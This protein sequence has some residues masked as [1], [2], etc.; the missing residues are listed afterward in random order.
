MKTLLIL[1]A[2]LFT[3][4]SNVFPQ[5]VGI[6]STGV[7]P[8]GS[9]MLD[10]VST[11]SGLLIPR[12]SMTQRDAISSPVEGLII[13]QTDNAPG[14]YYYDGLSWQRLIT[15]LTNFTESSYG[16][17]STIN[18]GVKLAPNSSQT[19]VDFVIAP[20]GVGGILAREPDGT[21]AGGNKR[22][23]CS[24]DFQTYRDSANQVAGG[25]QSFIGNGYGNRTGNQFSFIGNGLKNTADGMCTM[26]INGQNNT[27][28]K[29]AATIVNGL[30]NS[31]VGIYSIILNGMGDTISNNY[32][33][34]G[35]GRH[36]AINGI[37]SAIL[38]GYFNYTT[39]DYSTIINGQSDT[40]T[41]NY[42]FVHGVNNK[43]QSY[44][45]IVFGFNATDCTG[46]AYGIVATDRLFALGNGTSPTARSNALTILKNANTTVGGS[47]TINGNGSGTSY[48]FPESRGS[49][50]FVLTSDGSGGTTWAA[51]SLTNFIT[52]SSYGNGSTINY[53]VKLTPNS[54]QANVDLVISPK[55]TGALL[56][57]QPDGTTT[58]GNNRGNRSVDFQTYRTDATQVANGAYSF[59]GSGA[60]NTANADYSFVGGGS[61]N[62]ANAGY[63][64]VSGGSGNTANA[65]YSFVGGGSGN[66]ANAGYSLVAGGE[67]NTANSAYTSAV[68]GYHNTAIG[69]YSSIVGGLNNTAIGESSIVIGG[70]NN[71]CSGISSVIVG[72]MNNNCSG[73]FSFVGGGSNNYLNNDYSFIGSG[74]H[75][76]TYMQYSFIG[77]GYNN[78]ASGTQSFIGNGNNSI[79]SGDYSF[80][81]CGNNNTVSGNNAFIGGGELNIS[82]HICCFV[83][84][85]KMNSAGGIYC[86]VG[87][88]YNNSSG[89][90]YS[91]IAGGNGNEAFGKYSSINGG[92]YNT[93]GGDYS[94]VCGGSNNNANA[95]YS[96]VLYGRKAT[97]NSHIGAVMITDG[98]DSDISASA[99]H[100]M[101]MRF[102]GG[103]VLYSNAVLTT[104][105]TLPS[106]GGSWSSVS[107]STKKENFLRADPEIVLSAFRNFRLGSW[108][109]K[110]QDK[111][112][113]RHY[114]AMAQEW[115]S[116]FGHDGIGKIGDDTTLASADVDGIAYIAIKGLEK[117]TNE[118]LIVNNEQSVLIKKLQHRIETL[119]KELALS[120]ESNQKMMEK[121]AELA[122]KLN[123]ILKDKRRD[124][125]S[126]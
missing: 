30:R 102:S 104:G 111:Q 34:I 76:L 125:S 117:R 27:A 105:V 65:G 82:G 99:D 94:S 75:N 36:N 54:T 15:S 19:N 89:G 55:G 50:G 59:I 20:K 25:L 5:S 14:F 67:G 51:T 41:G 119:E 87:G 101:M 38:N 9:A 49:N 40:A 103:Y 26:V 18:Y 70:S 37:Y 28:S 47:L 66:L 60:S 121:F 83:G 68:G 6:N 84:G 4:Y 32:S 56:A 110:A 39:G 118:Q 97:T 31:V 58:G 17:G 126:K 92:Y 53:G 45:E 115:N 73:A 42:A 29:T 77:S 22:G 44:G 62:L 113:F 114:G 93:T 46:D 91:S 7:S 71:N 90:E 108:N 85:G 109:Y 35:N 2:F 98:N 21:P 81:G 61:G 13:Y 23:S 10:I 79:A 96:A 16:N 72:G 124:T 33:L 120:N 64:V 24:I 107:D 88:G 12:M 74:S 43:S 48:T 123:S 11:T 86:F 52:E 106:G 112:L 122:D 63:S 69:Q 3:V 8:D 100:Q 80:I 116:A 57:Q 95:N 1:L 78:E